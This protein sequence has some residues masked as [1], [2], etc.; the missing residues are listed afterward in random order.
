MAIMKSKDGKELMVECHCGCCDGIRFSIDKD[1][2]DYYCC[3]M[4]TNGKFYGEQDETIWRILCKKMKKI[5]AI[6][7]NKDYYYADIVLTKSEFNEFRQYVNAVYAGD[8]NMSNVQA[9]SILYHIGNNISNIANDEDAEV[10]LQAIETA[11]EA[12]R[13]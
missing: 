8:I 2:F 6:I 5:W 4:Y 3:M 7:R 11:V 10:Y 1:D 13:T 12:L 9:I